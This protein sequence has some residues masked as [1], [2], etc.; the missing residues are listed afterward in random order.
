[1]KRQNY[2]TEFKK[3]VALEAIKERKTLQEIAAEYQVA[4]SQVTRWREELLEGAG[5]L[6][7]RGSSKESK[8]IKELEQEKANLHQKIGEL[9]VKVDFLKKKLDHLE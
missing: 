3:K 8:Q 6:F 4:P 5:I 1:M 7:E 9:S 2:N